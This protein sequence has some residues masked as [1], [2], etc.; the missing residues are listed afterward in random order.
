MS[1]L[2]MC[3]VLFPFFALLVF[4]TNWTMLISL[5]CVILTIYY[6]SVKGIDKR[7]K[8]LAALHITM[9]FCLIMN[10][11]TVLVYWGVIHAKAID[12]F[13]GW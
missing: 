6:A 10:L 7:K 13:T 2:V 12:R 9:E 3:L 1:N 11:C 8:S 4:F 5:V